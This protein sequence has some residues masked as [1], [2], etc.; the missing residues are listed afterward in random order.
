MSVFLLLQPESNTWTKRSIYNRSISKKF[1][2][3]T[4][5][6]IE[7]TWYIH[8]HVYAYI[9]VYIV[10]YLMYNSNY[11]Q[12]KH[13]IPFFLKP[14]NFPQCIIL[15]CHA[16]VRWGQESAIS[17][18]FYFQVTALPVQPNKCGWIRLIAGIQATIARIIDYWYCRSSYQSQQLEGAMS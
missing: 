1:Q 2:P 15:L 4:S 17:N 18:P 7:L 5:I 11:L 9:Y 16:F 12:V 6:V 3:R 13:L 14:A 8:V 10:S